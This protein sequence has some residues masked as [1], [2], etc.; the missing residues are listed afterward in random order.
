MLTIDYTITNKYFP[1]SIIR[2]DQVFIKK[3][4]GF[5]IGDCELELTKIAKES[6][7]SDPFIGYR[8]FCKE[9]DYDDF[10]DSHD[11]EDSQLLVKLELLPL[12]YNDKNNWKVTDI[13]EVSALIKLCENHYSPTAKSSLDIFLNAASEIN[14]I[15]ILQ[16]KK[17]RNNYQSS[18]YWRNQV[19]SFIDSINKQSQH[20]DENA[21][22][23]AAVKR[24]FT[25]EI[26]EDKRYYINLPSVNQI[27][28]RIKENKKKKLLNRLEELKQIG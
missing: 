27:L 18:F 2:W 15:K 14:M 9:D 26:D 6:N 10:I 21:F 11:K 12:Y 20:I 28:D 3:T 19:N 7:I 22:I 8:I 23:V 17:P 4:D 13:N 25:V 16:G 24:G 5:E 1:I